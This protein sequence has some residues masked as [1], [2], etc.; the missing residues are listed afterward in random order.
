MREKATVKFCVEG[1]NFVAQGLAINGFVEKVNDFSIFHMLG[2]DGERVRGICLDNGWK[3][4]VLPANQWTK[5]D[6]IGAQI[7]LIR[8][9][10]A[11]VQKK[12]HK[13]ES[14]VF[15]QRFQ[16]NPVSTEEFAAVELPLELA[17]LPNTMQWNSVSAK[18]V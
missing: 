15:C 12:R 4:K 13:K 1:K 10:S 8:I 2:F 16:W 11:I 5:V 14:V 18:E 6:E 7:V 17:P 3:L 9:T